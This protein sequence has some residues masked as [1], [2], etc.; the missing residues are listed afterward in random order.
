MEETLNRNIFI[1]GDITSEKIEDV[2]R[3]LVE[4][5]SYDQL[6]DKQIKDYEPELIYLW[7]CSAGGEVLPVIGLVEYM[8]HGSTPI[9][10]VCVGEAC[11]AAFMIL[12][13][14]HFRLAVRGSSL[15]AHSM[16]GG[17]MG[18][19]RD[20]AVA[21]EQMKK[22]ESY[23]VDLMKNKTNIPEKMI[24]DM[25]HVQTDQYMSVEEALKYK[26]IDEIY[27]EPM[28]D[29]DDGSDDELEFDEETDDRPCTLN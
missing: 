2:M 16:S 5:T 17:Q 13:A 15:M 14:G 9:V 7:I 19:A 22:I 20:C 23:M 27:G 28:D 21:L 3:Q 11:S 8:M 10:T 6:I 25:Y 4:I 26:V 24:H 29:E 12:M 18:S 1:Y